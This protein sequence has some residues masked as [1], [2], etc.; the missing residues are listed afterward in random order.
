MII[1]EQIETS[2]EK[3]PGGIVFRVTLAPRIVL[4]VC[5]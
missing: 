2:N 5:T 1:R 3:L 4:T